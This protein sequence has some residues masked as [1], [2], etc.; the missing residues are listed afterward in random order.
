MLN[1]PKN[2][3]TNGVAVSSGNATVSNKDD[4]IT[5]SS[6]GKQRITSD[7][8]SDRVSQKAVSTPRLTPGEDIVVGHVKIAKADGRSDGACCISYSLVVDSDYRGLGL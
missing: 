3:E 6:P 1:I 5:S 4:E 7:D 2:V 8:A